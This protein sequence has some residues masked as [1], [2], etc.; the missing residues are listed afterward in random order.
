MTADGEDWLILWEPGSGVVP[1]TM[2]VHAI[3]PRRDAPDSAHSGRI[4]HECS[5]ETPQIP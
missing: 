1:G 4:S 5:S 3:T 2:V